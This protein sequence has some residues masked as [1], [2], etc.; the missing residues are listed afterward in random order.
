[1][2][3]AIGV[4]NL[5]LAQRKRVNSL[6]IS[7]V[8]VATSPPLECGQCAPIGIAVGLARMACNRIVYINLLRLYSLLVAKLIWQKPN[9]LDMLSSSLL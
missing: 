1:M 7:P 4:S 3:R 9:C 5:A 6:A 2:K 8:L